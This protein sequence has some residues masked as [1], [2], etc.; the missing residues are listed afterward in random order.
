MAMV[1]ASM[2]LGT[3]V[4]VVDVEK[5]VEEVG[6]VVGMCEAKGIRAL[7]RCFS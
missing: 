1:L 3:K 7:V 5:G 2:R 6:K 4:V